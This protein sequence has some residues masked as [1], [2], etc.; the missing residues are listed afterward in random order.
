MRVGVIDVGTNSVRLLITDGTGFGE[1]GLAITRLGQGVDAARRVAP[2]AMARTTDAIDAFVRR[3]RDADVER[4]RIVATSAVRDAVNRDEFLDMVRAR[5]GITPEVLTGEA[6]ARSSFAG[7]TAGLGAPGPFVVCDIGGG[8][9]E[10]IAG[11]ETI[12]FAAS[13]DIG[14]VRLTERHIVGDPPTQAELDA[15]AAAARAVLEPAFARVDARTLVGVAGSIT[16]TAAIVLG[17]SDYDPARIHHATITHDDVL[18][19]RA[20]LA[21]MTNPQ[22]AALPCMPPGREDVIVGGVVIFEQIMAVSG[23]TTCIVSETDILAGIAADLLSERAPGD[24]VGR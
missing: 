6:E 15:V 5:S 20:R 10:V 3:C 9:T 16:T 4:V 8:S 18:G 12:T 23:R 11:G 22:R 14:C 2:D 17:L 24:G 13:L 21:T 7:A 19:V 1:R